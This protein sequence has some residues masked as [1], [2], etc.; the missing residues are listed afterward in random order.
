MCADRTAGARNRGEQGAGGADRR[1]GC[2]SCRVATVPA[3]RHGGYR[4]AWPGR[5]WSAAVSLPVAAWLRSHLQRADEYAACTNA[6]ARGLAGLCRGT[7]R[8]AVTR[9][10]EESIDGVLQDSMV[11]V[12]PAECQAAGAAPGQSGSLLFGSWLEWLDG[13]VLAG[14]QFGQLWI[15]AEAVG[16]DQRSRCDG[17]TQSDNDV[18][19]AAPVQDSLDHT[20]RTIQ[21]GDDGHLFG[22]R[23]SIGGAR[24][25]VARRSVFRRIAALPAT[26]PFEGPQKIGLVGLDDARKHLRRAVGQGSQKPVSPPPG[27]QARDAQM[28]MNPVE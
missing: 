22:R 18:V 5:E 24:P 19:F 17:A 8:A 13:A 16:A 25:A 21:R 20:A 27:G 12:D 26:M 10:G 7:R 4:Q 11:T 2:R 6:Q 1:E 23:S 3:L 14:D 15:G 9:L 28:L